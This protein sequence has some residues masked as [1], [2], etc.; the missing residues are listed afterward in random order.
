MTL[1]PDSLLLVPFCPGCPGAYRPGE[2]GPF[3]GRPNRI[4]TI[5]IFTRLSQK[6][7]ISL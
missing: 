2:S 6:R 3:Y 4:L 1:I 7:I 5:F